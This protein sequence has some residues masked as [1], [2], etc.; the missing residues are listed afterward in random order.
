MNAWRERPAFQRREAFFL[1]QRPTTLC[2]CVCPCVG[3]NEA[4]FLNQSF[5][6]ACLKVASNSSLLEK[7][8]LRSS[9]TDRIRKHFFP[10]LVLSPCSVKLLLILIAR[11]TAIDEDARLLVTH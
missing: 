8:R 9:G 5:H 3:E 4:E 11:K 10:L 7:L 1:Q 6:P 2:V